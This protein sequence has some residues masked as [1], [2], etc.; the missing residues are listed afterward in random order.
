MLNYPQI[1][2]LSTTPPH[3]HGEAAVPALPLDGVLAAKVVKKRTKQRISTL[4]QSEK[5]G[6]GEVAGKAGRVPGLGIVMANGC[7]CL[8]CGENAGVVDETKRNNERNA[9]ADGEMVAPNGHVALSLRLSQC[10]QAPD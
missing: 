7:V 9:C 2:T 8:C 3:M 1:L 6:G 5:D 10:S 4:Y